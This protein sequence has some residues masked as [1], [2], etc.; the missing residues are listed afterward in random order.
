MAKILTR[1]LRNVAEK[2]GVLSGGAG[3]STLNT[4][5][6]VTY[7]HELGHELTGQQ[8]RYFSY[9]V[10]HAHSSAGSIEVLFD[11]G[12]ALNILGQF[13]Q[14][15]RGGIPSARWNRAEEDVWVLGVGVVVLSVSVLTIGTTSVVFDPGASGAALSPGTQAPTNALL[16]SGV[17]TTT[18]TPTQGG[19]PQIPGRI[20]TSLA[21]VQPT[22]F[23]WKIPKATTGRFIT[24]ST[25]GGSPGTLVYGFDIYC[26][27][28]P[29]GA[30]VPGA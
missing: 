21:M 12:S 11:P 16:F 25:V 10:A 18:L 6:G 30:L 26:V 14:G 29:A 19:L 22:N 8:A 5:E 7:V 3:M 20:G 23:P 27:K 17:I 13:P 28:V 1:L 15:E 24:N 9:T 2:Y 4:Q